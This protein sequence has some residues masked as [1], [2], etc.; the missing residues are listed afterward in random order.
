VGARGRLAVGIVAAG[1]ALGVL[2]DGLFR[3]RPVG[4]NAFLFAGAFVLA[5]AALLRVGRIPFHQGR[6]A[7]LV[8]LLLFAA[9]L[10]WHDSPLLV[11]ANLFAIAGAVVLGALRRTQP[12][13]GAADVPDYASGALS[14]GAS[15]IVGAAVL[16]QSE[17]PWQQVGE[18]LGGSRSRAVGRGVA[19]SLPLVA[20]FGGLFVAADAVFKSYVSAALPGSAVWTDV[21]IVVLIG[22]VCAGLLRDLLATREEERVLS[23]PTPS[24]RLG[25][26]EV[27][28]PL[29]A[30]NLLFLAFVLVQLRYL[31]GGESLVQERL[32]LTYAQYARHGFFELVAVSLL[33][34]PI[35]VFAGRAANRITRSLCVTLVAL[36]LVVMVSAL[37]RMRLYEHEYGLTEL[38]LYV[39]GVE[40]WLAVVFAWLVYTMLRSD[41]R[42]F[43]AGAV[44]AGFVATLAL[45]VLNPDA[46]IARTN[47]DRQRVDVGYVGSL[48]DDAVP[49]LVA[50]VPSLERSQQR[51]LARALLAREPSGS[52]LGWNA[53]RARARDVLAA[54]RFELERLA[55]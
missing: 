47:L 33:V 48:S 36:V 14:A 55:R 9:L 37:D 5:L 52:L 28:I 15:S 7:M 29:A 25:K 51:T 50:R 38:R 6:R 13:L 44:A 21:V 34:L 31:F 27:A 32:H 10:A 4:V 43:M 35:V 2:G 16:M 42:R 54:H 8:P 41:T 39:T 1:T 30:L 18:R 26:A 11:A 49:T 17:V 23:T 40:L 12:S 3:D 45:N 53:S 46:L 19:L 20:V 24:L 22:W